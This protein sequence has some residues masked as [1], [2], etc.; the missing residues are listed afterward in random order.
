VRRLLWLLAV[1]GRDRLRFAG[2]IALGTLALASAVGL[3]AT[4]AWLAATVG[5]TTVLITH[6]LEGLDAVDEVVV[7]D[8]GRIVE[9]GAH[10]TLL[11]AGGRYR[12]LWDREC[13]S[14]P[15]AAPAVA[16]AVAPE[17]LPVVFAAARGVEPVRE[18]PR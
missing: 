2:A 9:R 1:S 17:V 18:E 3:M 16:P 10:A 12:E 14:S 13:A 5:R 11:R 8:R 7:L 6:R 4:S 15:A